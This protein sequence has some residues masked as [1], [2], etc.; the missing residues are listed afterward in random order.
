MKFSVIHPTARVTEG[1]AHHWTIA[2]ERA[3]NT[4]DNWWDVEYILVVHE[5]R[6]VYLNDARMHFPFGRFQIVINYGRDC[7]VDQCNAG[8]IAATGEIQIWNQDD[9]RYPEHWDTEILKLI[10]DTSQLV[11][12]QARTDGSRS[13]LLTLPS[14]MTRP[15]VQALGLLSPDYESMFS[16]DETSAKVWRLGSI[17]KSSLYFQHLHPVNGTAE[18][19][20]MYALENRQEAYGVGFDVFQKRKAAGF[21]RVPFPGERSAETPAIVEEDRVIAICTPGDT[22]SFQWLESFLNLGSR[23]GQEKYSCKRYMGHASNVYRARMDLAERV[24]EDAKISGVRPQYVL[25]LDSD[26]TMLPDQL[27][28][29]LR[30]MRSYPDVDAIFGWCWI[31]KAH[32]WTTSAGMFWPDD[33]VHLMAYN[34]DALF[35]GQTDKERWA[36]KSIEHSGFPAALIRYDAFEQLG[37]SAFR[38]LTKADLP[39][40]FEGKMPE[41]EVTPDWF[42]GEDTAWC[43]AAKKA[44]MKLIVD[45]GCKLGHLKIQSQEPDVAAM[46]RS[47]FSENDA[48]EF[49]AGFNGP[50][51]QVPAE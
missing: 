15:L 5:S 13:D 48:K 28:G 31:R 14:I 41:K 26:N 1:V 38:P 23:L 11:A 46:L 12:V 7:L 39:A 33:G 32:G 6:A 19:D 20:E 22:F 4:C 27:V 45:P 29:L 24:I 44:G 3:L 51:V 10:P 18:M 50:E 17:V 35:A 34:P 25:W 37:D 30:F 2:A 36:P 9:M 42:C 47:G 43:L 16:D 40:Y 21:P 8:S 49:R